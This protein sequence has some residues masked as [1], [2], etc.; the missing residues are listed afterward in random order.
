MIITDN[1]NTN[2]YIID[3]NMCILDNEIQFI[4]DIIY[5]KAIH[6]QFI[7]QIVSNNLNGIDVDKLPNTSHLY[8]G[9]TLRIA[10]IGRITPIKNLET[11]INAVFELKKKEPKIQVVLFGDCI[12]DSDKKYKNDLEKIIEEKCLKNNVSFAG[13]VLYKD[14]PARLSDCHITVNMSPS[15][16]MDKAV[17]ESILLGMP[18]FVANPAFTGVLGEY[19]DLFF[20]KYGDSV[21][22]A[23]KIYNFIYTYSANNQH[24]LNDLNNKVRKD[25]S[26]ENL[27]DK[28]IKEMK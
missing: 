8:T 12:T 5:P 2:P 21:D 27:I 20:Y 16:G 18:T 17:L 10:H 14:I 4:Q 6:T 25:F 26:L 3:N 19:A 9:N 15:G 13:N 28:V 23:Q 24:V 1:V 7:Y 22:L 11:L